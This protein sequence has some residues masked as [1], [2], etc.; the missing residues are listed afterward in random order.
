MKNLIFILIILLSALSCKSPIRDYTKSE[1]DS[2]LLYDF[3]DK[4]ISIESLTSQWN[5]RIQD[6][7]EINAKIENLEIVSIIDNKTNKKILVLLGSTN[8]RSIKTAT[9]LSKF[10]NGLKLSD[11]TVTCKNC[12][13]D[14]NIQLSNGNWNCVSDEN[15][16]NLCTK[17]ETLRSE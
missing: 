2:I 1:I 6:N 7:E 14:L 16:N 12:T 11:I 5:K 10:K 4:P 8:R 9:K 3:N 17:I 13:S 15:E